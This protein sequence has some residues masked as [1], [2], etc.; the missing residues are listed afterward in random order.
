MHVSVNGV[1]LFFDV[2]GLSLPAIGDRLVEKPTMILIHGGPGFDHAPFKP[3]YSRFSDLAQIVYIDLR[4]NGRS[5]AGPP[6]SWT[7]EQWAIDIKDFC[8]NLSI[9]RPIVTG[10]SFGG[11]VAMRYATLFP[12]HPRALILSN[13]AARTN[14]DRKLAAFEA[15]G[16]PLA[17]S[18]AKAFWEAPDET[19]VANYMQHCM[20]LYTPADHDP[21][22]GARGIMRLES[23]FTFAGLGN[24][25]F[26]YDFRNELAKIECPTLVVTGDKDPI[27]PIGDAQEIF[28]HLP[29]HRRH[30]EIVS[31]AGH[32]VERAQPEAYAKLVRD[33]IQQSSCF[34]SQSGRC[35]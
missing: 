2:E 30:L 7:L 10:V 3:Y 16:G 29:E 8:D 4:A 13:T 35:G 24:E 12:E 18:A 15:Q 22:M 33:F 14:M 17:K 26:T 9:E 27:T 11:F 34:D 32:S 20:P 25:M 23:F 31:E 21:L 19:A 1:R 5:E 28:D 6:Q